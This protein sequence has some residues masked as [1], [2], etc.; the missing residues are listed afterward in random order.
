MQKN[1]SFDLRLSSSALSVVPISPPENKL[2]AEQQISVGREWP[3][4]FG[5]IKFQ[6]I[7]HCPQLLH[8][9]KDRIMIIT[10]AAAD[11]FK[12]FCPQQPSKY[13]QTA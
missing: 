3:V 2:N 6:L 7:R 9:R 13:V 4:G 5:C 1:L 10:G 11:L 12:A 8:S